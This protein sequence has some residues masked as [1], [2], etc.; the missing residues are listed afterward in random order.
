MKKI[1]CIIFCFLILS[2]GTAYSRTVEDLLRE[3][4]QLREKGHRNAAIALYDLALKKDP[5][6]I[7]AI[8]EFG[9]F[10]VEIRNYAHAI[11]MYKR[12]LTLKPDDYQIRGLVVDIYASL[13]QLDQAMSESLDLLKRDPGNLSALKKIRK[14]YSR[15]KLYREE[16]LISEKILQFEPDNEEVYSDLLS[17]C[18]LSGEFRK[19]SGYLDKRGA[20]K[21][22]PKAKI[23]FI[24]LNSNEYDKAIDIFKKIYK[25]NPT[26][27]NKSF[28]QRAQ[29]L[30]IN[31]SVSKRPR[32]FNSYYN[33]IMDMYRRSPNNP[34]FRE[35]KDI[36]KNEIQG[37]Y[38]GYD[39]T[40]GRSGE[41]RHSSSFAKI[42]Y[43]ILSTGT[44]LSIIGQ[45]YKIWDSKRTEKYR[46]AGLGIQQ[47][48][49]E[50]FTFSGAFSSG[51]PG[52]IY[53]GQIHYQ[54]ESVEAFI[55]GRKDYQIQTPDALRRKISF[56]GGNVYANWS[57]MER[58]GM[59]GHLTRYHYSDGNNA[60]YYELGAYYRLWDNKKNSSLDISLYNS[61]EDFD[62]ES[63]YYFSPSN[64]SQWHTYAEF[65][66]YWTKDSLL[67]L[68]YAY[69]WD[70][71]NNKYNVY[72]GYIDHKFSDN[73]FLYG[74]YL[75]GLSRAG[76]IGSMEDP[77]S[78]DYEVKM[79]VKIKF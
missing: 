26:S 61:N 66:Y 35:L 4:K 22:F 3:A 57:I 13:D 43:P 59:F 73:S 6:N 67:R 79:G 7:G 74:E 55:Q 27:E 45:D 38:A 54:G 32:F 68:S 62:N 58:L 77:N 63:D 9:D 29:L 41:H 46:Q 65:N 12:Y 56:S 76:R 44:T 11:K 71:N 75:S 31:N 2:I 72:S 48:L 10:M 25:E 18:I 50:N 52:S 36:I 5:D 16:M 24:Y 17:A 42:S 37:I 53:Y 51:D 30:K 47:S 60:R 8:R 69:T 19:A 23:G 49:G 33:P 28:L 14:I 64:L 39:Y 20:P 40:W 15:S 1:V 78:K 21:G 34:R 70:K